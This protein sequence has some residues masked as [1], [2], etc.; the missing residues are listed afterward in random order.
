[1]RNSNQTYD[2][3]RRNARLGL[4][5]DYPLHDLLLDFWPSVVLGISLAGALW[6]FTLYLINVV[7]KA[8]DPALASVGVDEMLLGGGILL[9]F[10]G[11]IC[12][13]VSALVATAIALA[14][15]L[16]L[17]S[18]QVDCEHLLI[19]TL[20]GGTVGLLLALPFCFAQDPSLLR[21]A[22]TIGL[23]TMLTQAGGTWGA[24]RMLSA[25]ARSEDMR[26]VAPTSFRFGTRQ[27]FLVTVWSA[28]ILTVL[29]L[30]DVLHEPLLSLIAIWFLLQLALMVVVGLLAKYWLIQRC[31]PST[32]GSEG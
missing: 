3:H 14:M 32:S 20:T 22:A 13:G 12:L 5:A 4:P 9:L 28:A 24:W 31:L 16:I 29:K 15:K 23:A 10:G 6:P 25:R 11:S 2:R 26:R 17:R 8:G 21:C 18:L 30:M 1:M 27:M 7:E 19:G